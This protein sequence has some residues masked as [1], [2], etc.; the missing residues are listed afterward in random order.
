MIQEI[1]EFL[2]Y[3]DDNLDNLISSYMNRVPFENI[4]VQNKVPISVE[5][6]DLFDKII[7]RGR[8]GFLCEFGS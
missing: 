8:G 6:G 3:P 2:E 5:L 1:D 4:D 7:T